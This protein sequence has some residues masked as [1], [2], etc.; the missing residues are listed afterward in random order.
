VPALSAAV[1]S[2]NTVV[3]AELAGAAGHV[4]YLRIMVKRDSE[5]LST[6]D[7]ARVLGMVSSRWVRQQVLAGRLPATAITVGSR[8]VYRIRRSDLD[9]FRVKYFRNSVDRP[10]D[11]R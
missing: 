11:E 10:P 3:E 4:D 6:D 7:A 2:A 5:W 8:P 1:S 9:A